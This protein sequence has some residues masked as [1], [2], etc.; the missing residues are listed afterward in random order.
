MKLIF[1][2][3]L[4]GAFLSPSVDAKPTRST[5]K[6]SIK[7]CADQGNG[8]DPNLNRRKNIRSDNRNAR[9]RSIQWMKALADP[10]NFAK[11]GSRSELTR[12]GEGQNIADV[13]YALGARPEGGE[14][15]QLRAHCSEGHR[16]SHRVD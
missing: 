2:A 15:L 5:A 16:Q 3:L 4:L 13:A 14:N 9:R 1:L 12:L 10:K 8:G 6:R 11:G 7:D